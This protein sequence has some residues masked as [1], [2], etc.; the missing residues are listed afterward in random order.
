MRREP[1]CGR[2]RNPAQGPRSPVEARSRASCA[3][4][5]GSSTSIARRR[6][7]AR[8]TR[9]MGCLGPTLL[10]SWAIACGGQGGAG[11]SLPDSGQP[12]ASSGSSWSAAS[13]SITPSSGSSSQASSGGISPQCPPAPA[14][15]GDWC[16]DGSIECAHFAIHGNICQVETCLPPAHAVSHVPAMP[17]PLFDAGPPVCEN[18]PAPP[19]QCETCQD[20]TVECA[21]YVQTP[22][23]GGDYVLQSCAETPVGCVAGALCMSEPACVSSAAGGCAPSCDCGATGTLEC[24]AE[25]GDG[26]GQTPVAGCGQ[27]AA[28]VSGAMC[29]TPSFASLTSS[30]DVSC[31]CDSTAGSH[32]PGHLQCTDPCAVPA[33]GSSCDGGTFTIGQG[34]FSESSTKC[35]DGQWLICG[36]F[37]GRGCD[38]A[39]NQWQIG[40][41]NGSLPAEGTPCCSEDYATNGLSIDGCCAGGRI[42]SC[43]SNHIVYGATCGSSDAGLDSAQAD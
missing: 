37:F 27:G 28:C 9:T 43:V 30:A 32:L 35:V 23:S 15:G 10:F 36:P 33:A 40:S 19:A 21:H 39:Y 12:A 29:R 2:L 34:C 7:L 4:L 5:G 25:S 3:S 1:S 8:A 38:P 6:L 24:V 14:S 13:G 20:G 31:V 42:V 22:Q 16:S 18:L 26:G 17:G 41:F 11:T